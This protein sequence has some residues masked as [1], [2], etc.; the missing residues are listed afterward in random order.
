M[1]PQILVH[2]DPQI[3]LADGDE[4]HR[5]Q[6]CIG[7]EVVHLHLIVAAKR[8]EETAGGNARAPLVQPRQADDVTARGF[9]SVSDPGAIHA[10]R[11]GS[12]FG[13]RSPAATSVSKNALSAMDLPQGTGVTIF[14]VFTMASAEGKEGGLELRE[15]ALTTLFSLSAICSGTLT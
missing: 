4:D 14:T 9:G 13:G 12:V 10:G 8:T 3:A 5:L 6:D 7:G 1:P 2:R 11:A 15:G